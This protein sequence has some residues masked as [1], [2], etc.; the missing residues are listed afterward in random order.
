MTI[1][2]E[3]GFLLLHW[4]AI[5]DHQTARIYKFDS[6]EG[7][8]VL[9][10]QSDDT[11]KQ[12]IK[13][14]S[15]IHQ[16]AWHSEF[17]RV[18]L[19]NSNSCLSSARKSIAELVENSV[20]RLYPSVFVGGEQFADSIALNTTASLMAVALPAQGVVD[21]YSRPEDGWQTWQRI[22]VALSKISLTRKIDLALSPSGDTLAALITDENNTPELKIIERFGE[23]W[24]ESSSQTLAGASMLDGNTPE[25]E[26]PSQV[27]VSMAISE[28]SNQMLLSIGEDIFTT[29]R[30]LS[31]W[32]VP[33]LLQQEH[34]QP[35]SIAFTERFS[36]EAVFKA[37]SANS[38]H[39]RLFT[40]HSFDQSLWLGVWEQAT[41]ESATPVWNKISAFAINNVN[42]EKEVSIHSDSNGDQLLIAGWEINNDIKHTPVL[43]RY[44]IPAQPT[45]GAPSNT[46]LSVVDS[47]R[48]PFAATNSAQLRFSAD[49]SLNQIVIG[50][51][52]FE[53]TD[54]APD[55]ALITYK[56]S[57]SAMR[58][59]PK[60]ELPEV[61]PTF[62]KQSFVRSALL[63]ADG[64][65]MIIS[66][67]AGQS[68]AGENKV[69]E[70]M[71]FH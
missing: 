58:W 43:W 30:S 3:P 37:I 69:G 67:A 40:V 62:A 11:K 24:F 54:T 26:L 59:L 27:S 7:F 5:D 63:S 68:L 47:L 20:Q 38:T 23:A 21:L 61:F 10:A 28:N 34:Y 33:R 57:Q 18:E 44:E 9:V 55:A 19:C 65:S 13:I 22:P 39:T 52:N 12:T 36:T 1:T 53:S 4:E 35:L 15:K 51:Q 56:F 66:I 46:E 8:E 41:E 45:A 2:A 42:S 31:G 25:L 70:L 14:P 16:R 50:W 29:Y 48:F 64:E 6:Y 32:A 60:L 17:F 71:A 49:D